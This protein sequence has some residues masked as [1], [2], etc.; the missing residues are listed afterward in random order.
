MPG[1]L[2]AFCLAS[3]SRYSKPNIRSSAAKIRCV[4]V[5]LHEGALQTD[6]TDSGETQ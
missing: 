1:A 4:S 6:E 2:S 3:V 5:S